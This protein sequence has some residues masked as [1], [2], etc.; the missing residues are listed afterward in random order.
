M[1]KIRI[2]EIIK[3]G[4]VCI[5]KYTNNIGDNLEATLNMNFNA[6]E[7]DYLEKDVGIGGTVDV[8]IKS[9]KPNPKGGFYVTNS[10]SFI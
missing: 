6:Q 7:V 5:V 9:D 1:E 3:R 8:V 2:N 10:S 4:V